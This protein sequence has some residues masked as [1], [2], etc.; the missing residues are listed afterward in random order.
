MTQPREIT[1]LVPKCNCCD[2]NIVLNYNVVADEKFSPITALLEITAVGLISGTGLASAYIASFSFKKESLGLADTKATTPE[3]AKAKA[4]RSLH[5]RQLLYRRLC[6]FVFVIKE[7]YLAS[8][9]EV[10]V[11]KR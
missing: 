2:F 3:E 1:L 5:K 11:P 8:P 6:P 9:A 4:R 10:N 7:A